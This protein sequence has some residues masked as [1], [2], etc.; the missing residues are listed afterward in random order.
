MWHSGTRNS[1]SCFHGQPFT[2]LSY[3][4]DW[5][6]VGQHL[7]QCSCASCCSNTIMWISF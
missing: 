3:V 4:W 1:S 2:V 5:Q 7:D 6:M